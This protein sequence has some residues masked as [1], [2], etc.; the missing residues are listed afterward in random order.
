MPVW[1]LVFF[2]RFFSREIFCVRFKDHLIINYL[3]IGK[4]MKIIQIKR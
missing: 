4:G 2:L 3:G 1:L